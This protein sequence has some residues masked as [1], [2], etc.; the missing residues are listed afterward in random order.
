[1]IWNQLGNFFQTDGKPRHFSPKGTPLKREFTINRTYENKTNLVARWWLQMRF[2]P[3]TSGTPF[4]RPF[5]YAYFSTSGSNGAFS[6]PGATWDHFRCTVE[7][8]PGHIRCRVLSHQDHGKGGLSLRGVAFMT[9][10]TVLAVL[11]STLP[12]ICLSH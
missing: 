5:A 10:L 12:S 4:L 7:P 2:P 3:R 11:E 9:V 1:M 8:S 6:L